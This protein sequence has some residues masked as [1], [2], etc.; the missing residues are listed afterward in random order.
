MCGGSGVRT[1]EAGGLWGELG[2][3]APHRDT[4]AASW[5]NGLV[6]RFG[7]D[8]KL[9]TQESGVTRRESVPAKGEKPSPGDTGDGPGSP[10][11]AHVPQYLRLLVSTPEGT[12]SCA[13]ENCRLGISVCV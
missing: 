3:P 9:Q 11:L 4:W 12:Q 2:Q 5:K 10:P 13:Q 8:T 1:L 6:G 7:E